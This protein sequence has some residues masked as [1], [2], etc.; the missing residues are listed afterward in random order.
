MTQPTDTSRSVPIRA[1]IL[2]FAGVLTT[3]VLETHRQWCLAQGLDAEAW[4]RTLNYTDEG[5]QLYAALEIGELSQAEW[6]RR[7][8]P[9]LGIG[10]DGENLMGR[11]W[12]G[13]RPAEDMIRLA[14]DARAAGYTLALLSNSFGLDPYNPYEAIGVWDLFDVHVISETEGIAKPD[15]AIYQRTLDRLG[16]RG[17]ECVFVDDHPVNLPPAAALGI[18]TVLADG[19]AAACAEV[20]AI[21]GLCPAQA[22]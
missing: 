18:T 17:E 13:V 11:S 14:R 5:R 12:A 19:S 21:L 9:L 2:D 22:A 10:D 3:G 7:T 6:N 1:L 20:A 16:L 8:A 15:P 4:R